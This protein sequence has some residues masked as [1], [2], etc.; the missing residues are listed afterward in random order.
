V[1]QSPR[2]QAIAELAHAGQILAMCLLA[3]NPANMDEVA[4]HSAAFEAAVADGLDPA[5]RTFRVTNGYI[6]F[7]GLT[8]GRWQPDLPDGVDPADVLERPAGDGT[9]LLDRLRELLEVLSRLLAERQDDSRARLVLE[10]AVQACEAGHSRHLLAIFQ[11]ELEPVASGGPAAASGG[12]DRAREYIREVQGVLDGVTEIASQLRAVPHQDGHTTAAFL[13][14]CGLGR[15]LA[16]Q[17]GPDPESTARELGWYVATLCRTPAS[18]PSDYVTRLVRHMLGRGHTAIVRD[19]ADGEDREGRTRMRAALDAASTDELGSILFDALPHELAAMF[20]AAAMR[21]AV[22]DEQD[23]ASWAALAGNAEERVVRMQG[24]FL[25]TALALRDHNVFD[26]QRRYVHG[27]RETD[28]EDAARRAARDFVE[29]W[30]FYPRVTL[31]LLLSDQPL[32]QGPAI[33]L[34]T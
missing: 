31:P 14:A 1:T 20:V 27:L 30:L 12:K 13:V 32:P 16:A 6:Q 25:N 17:A 9:P 19:L 5:D 8:E 11:A 28:G 4:A 15:R 26:R 18:E 10:L 2:D 29:G 24:S 21:H 22:T 33:R 3:S 34:G 23:Q 7:R